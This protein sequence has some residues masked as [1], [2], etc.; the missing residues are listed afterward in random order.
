M[1]CDKCKCNEATFHTSID[2]GNIKKTINLCQDCASIE[3]LEF[4]I[5]DEENDIE[6][7][8]SNCGYTLSLFKSTGLLGCSD[9]YNVFI[10]DINNVIANSQYGVHH[11]GKKIE[12][13]NINSTSSL[14]K[15]LEIQLKQ[16]A[17]EENYAV[18]SKIKSQIRDLKEN[19]DD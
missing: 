18:A 8:C 3:D 11:I 7:T 13:D 15:K 12:Q 14:I 2:N 17:N 10:D 16:A 4:N 5:L 9:C 6:P 1:L 19:L